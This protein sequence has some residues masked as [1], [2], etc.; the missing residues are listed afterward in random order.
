MFHL[1]STMF[2]FICSWYSEWRSCKTY[3]HSTMFIFIFKPTCTSR[4]WKYIYIP[5]CL[6]L[7]IA[8]NL[9]DGFVN[10]FTFH[11]VYI[12][13]ERVSQWIS[14]LWI[15]IPLCLYLYTPL[16]NFIN[17]SYF[18]KTPV[19]KHLWPLL[20]LSGFRHFARKW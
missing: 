20:I 18:V 14:V 11:Y 10:L 3:L 15:Y 19:L 9:L 1:H 13:I 17:D 2:I 16:Y 6:Y 12:Y 5:L 4:R 7:Y 8:E